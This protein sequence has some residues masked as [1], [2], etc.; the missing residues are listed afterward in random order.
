MPTECKITSIKLYQVIE[1][2]LKF[3]YPQ[4]CRH[5]VALDLLS[6]IEDGGEV[7]DPELVKAITQADDIKSLSL[8]KTD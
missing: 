4:I 6:L 1:R 8:L 5:S 3:P 7:I 2:L